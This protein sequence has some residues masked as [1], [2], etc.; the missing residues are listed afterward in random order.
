[1]EWRTLKP[2]QQQQ[3]LGAVKCFNG[4]KTQSGRTRLSDF[5]FAYNQATTSPRTPPA[6]ILPI[7][8]IFLRIFD[9][10]LSTSVCPIS[11][12]ISGDNT[13]RGDT[14]D[15][16]FYSKTAAIDPLFHLNYRN[17]DRLWALWQAKSAKN[18]NEF[19]AYVQKLRRYSTPEDTVTFS[20]LK[21]H[22]LK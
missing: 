16:A 3:Y 11:E 14:G 19:V 21:K 1:V 7:Q 9:H 17:I 4:L 6:A 15:L 2:E 13:N 5:V 12:E 20:T 8:R 10:E 22:I 18:A